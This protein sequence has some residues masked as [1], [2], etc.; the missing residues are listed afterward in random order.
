MTGLGLF[1]AA[2]GNRRNN[3]LRFG[4]RILKGGMLF[5]QVLRSNAA[6]DLR[7]DTLLYR[8]QHLRVRKRQRVY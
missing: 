5:W 6:I 8:R 7:I 1:D 3:E 4:A 2:I